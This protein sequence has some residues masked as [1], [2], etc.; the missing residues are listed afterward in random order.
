MVAHGKPTTIVSDNGTC[1]AAASILMDEEAQSLQ[2]RPRARGSTSCV[3]RRGAQ[4]CAE[5]RR[6]R[7]AAALDRPGFHLAQA[8]RGFAVVMALSPYCCPSPPRPAVPRQSADRPGKENGPPQ[9]YPRPKG[10]YDTLCPFSRPHP[11]LT[12]HAELGGF[13]NWRL[14][15]QKRGARAGPPLPGAPGITRGFIGSRPS[16]C[17]FLRASLRAR[18]MAS[19][20]SR[21][22]FSEGFS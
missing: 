7:A 12:H 17:N 20:F 8:V 6:C 13:F 5:I 10:R 16:R 14:R 19:A 15:D 3:R 21:T 11:P 4:S 9:R 1:I 22:L 18:R 2:L